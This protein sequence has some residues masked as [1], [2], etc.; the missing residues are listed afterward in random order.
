MRLAAERAAPDEGRVAAPILNGEVP[1]VGDLL[2]IH[3]E[4][5]TEPVG[6]LGAL[7]WRQVTHDLGSAGVLNNPQFSAVYILRL[8]ETTIM[9][10]DN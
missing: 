10:S 2:P 5:E 9:W 8:F 6:A 3:L 4:H 7:A 1:G